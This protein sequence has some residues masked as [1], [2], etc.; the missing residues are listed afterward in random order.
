[1]WTLGS[2]LR[3]LGLAACFTFAFSRSSLRAQQTEPVPP[4]VPKS[5]L[6]QALPRR[7]Y[8]CADD[9]RIVVLIETNAVRLMFNG[10]VHN[11]KQVESG[12]GT[13]YSDGL[14]VW[15]VEGDDWLFEEDTVPGKPQILAKDCH[16]SSVYPPGAPARGTVTGTASYR[17]RMA[18][19]PNSVAIVQLHD[20]SVADP[21][22]SVLADFKTTFG[23]RQVPIP[24]E[25]KFDPARIDPHHIYSV[26]A[27]ILVDNQ[28]RFVTRAPYHVLT[29]GNPTKVDLVLDAPKTP[30][31]AKP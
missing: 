26:T 13:R 23:D 27:R 17:L 20:D 10:Q 8:R 30:A 6:R 24:F 1:M 28:I 15:F 16:L 22:G 21:A 7:E 12:S 14:F 19:P 5:H 29:H 31:P 3:F 18:L 25:L 9:A 4:V 2:H 11:L